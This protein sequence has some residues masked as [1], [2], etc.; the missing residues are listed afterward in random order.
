[1]KIVEKFLKGKNKDQSLC[2]DDYFFGKNYVLVVDGATSKNNIK[3]NNVSGGKMIATIVKNTIQYYDK[4]DSVNFEKII[5][6][7]N[8]KIQSLYKKNNINIKDS[9]N[10]SAAS[11]ILYSNIERKIYTIGDCQALLINKNNNVELIN[12]EKEI[13]ILMSK[14]RSFIIHYLKEKEYFTIDE[15]LL[16]DKGR[17]MIV[18]FLKMQS[19]F[20]NNEIKYGY[21][22][23]DGQE[24]KYDEYYINQDVSEIVL[25][26]DGYPSL[27]R[28]LEDSENYLK[29]IL[30]KDPLMYNLFLSTKGLSKNNNSFDDRTYLRFKL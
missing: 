25:S 1:L 22:V 13:D 19:F 7:I 9:N 18:P 20:Q 6:I 12:N 5:T 26:S 15:L 30:E 8:K 16:N 3:Y 23:I 21:N 10:L 28:T 11:F 2:E 24:T 4:F 17:E 14:L 29:L 27:K